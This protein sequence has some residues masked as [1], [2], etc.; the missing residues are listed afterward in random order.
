VFALLEYEIR[1]QRNQEMR[2][3][4]SAFQKI[5]F[6]NTCMKALFTEIKNDELYSRMD[7]DNAVLYPRYAEAIHKYNIRAPFKI[8]FMELFEG[9]CYNWYAKFVAMMQTRNNT[10][11]KYYDD[12]GDDDDDDDDDIER[13]IGMSYAEKNNTSIV[14]FL[15]PRWCRLQFNV[16]HF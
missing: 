4:I 16:I 10:T 2:E 12:I 13:N 11:D 5:L 9:L 8:M 3:E 14:N 1:V 6:E 15:L 7:S